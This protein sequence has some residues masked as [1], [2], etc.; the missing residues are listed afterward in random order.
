MNSATEGRR[1]MAQLSELRQQLVE[2]F[3]EKV[4]ALLFWPDGKPKGLKAAK[5]PDEYRAEF[6]GSVPGVGKVTFYLDSD[7]KQS[8]SMFEAIAL[9][10][11][12]LNPDSQVAKAVAANPDRRKEQLLAAARD[13]ITNKG[14]DLQAVSHL[15][16][17][18]YRRAEAT[19]GDNALVPPALA[20]PAPPPDIA[21]PQ[22]EIARLGDLQEE[23]G[24]T[25]MHR[26]P[27]SSQDHGALTTPPRRP[28]TT[29]ALIE[30]P[31]G[32]KGAQPLVRSGAKAAGKR[33]LG[34][35]PPPDGRANGGADGGKRAMSGGDGGGT[36]GKRVETPP[37]EI[38]HHPAKYS[39][40]ANGK[41][42]DGGDG[43]DTS[44]EA[45]LL[46]IDLLEEDD[47]RELAGWRLRAALLAKDTPYWS[48]MGRTRN[49]LQA[50]A[51]VTHPHPHPH[52]HPHRQQQQHHH[53]H[54]HPH[55][56]PH[57]HPHLHPHPH[58][59]TRTRTPHPHPH[60]HPHQH[61]PP[62]PAPAP[63]YWSGMG[64]L[65]GVWIA[66]PWHPAGCRS[67]QGLRRGRDGVFLSL[68]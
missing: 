56:H 5:R 12:A 14:G 23:M 58:P 4:V 62:A 48:T 46:T 66:S 59:L 26:T 22:E 57:P 40:G 1:A 44:T 32:G 3:G 64:L 13:R 15:V 18:T 6:S 25:A 19:L 20:P 27:G 33:R 30:G 7:G 45:D 9:R 61:L 55:P 43:G 21:P 65:T 17:T 8:C 31:D 51:A 68:G 53:L 52:P 63:A 37:G 24:A 10:A 2:E 36:N 29:C 39:T 11:E 16:A 42:A 38:L 60:P 28:R 35:P 54:H 67:C 34:D 49:V 41:R 50:I 47:P